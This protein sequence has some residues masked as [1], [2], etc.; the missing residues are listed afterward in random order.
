MK[1]ADSC[2]FMAI[3]A[4]MEGSKSQSDYKHDKKTP[5]KCPISGR[6]ME[7]PHDDKTGTKQKKAGMSTIGEDSTAESQEQTEHLR[8]LSS[9]SSSGS[10]RSQSTH[11]HNG[12]LAGS[13]VGSQVGSRIGSHVGSHM[14]S[15]ASGIRA[16]L[17]ASSKWVLLRIP[18]SPSLSSPVKHSLTLLLRAGSPPPSPAGA[19]SHAFRTHGSEAHACLSLLCHIGCIGMSLSERRE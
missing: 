17:P 6:A 4:A 16:N 14:G 15:L 1:M 7:K 13:H 19:R 10:V 5:L 2:P 18:P 8:V 12:S 11:S 9:G 3:H